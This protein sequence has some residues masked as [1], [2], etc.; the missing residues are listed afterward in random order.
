M[1]PVKSALSQLEPGSPQSYKGL[2]IFPLKSSTGGSINYLLLSEALEAG[3]VSVRESSHGG[4]VPDLEVENR[5][6]RPV[7]I[8]DGEEL[9]GAKQNRV[10]N[11]PLLVPAAKRTT[12]PV[13]CVEAGR[14][15]Y[16]SDEFALS[17]R[18]HFARGRREK[19]ASVQASMRSTGSRYSDQ[20]AV[21]ASIDDKAESMQARSPTG[22]MGSIFEKHAR[23]L[24]EFVNRLQAVPG[25]VGGVFCVAGTICGMD[26]FDK[27]TTFA[28]LLPKLVRSYGIDALEHGSGTDAAP[29]RNA[30]S[31]FLGSLCEGRL[32]EHDAVGLGH[33]VRVEAAGIVA[34]GLMVDSELIHLAAFA[35]ADSRHPSMAP[36]R[37]FATVRQRR[38]SARQR[39]DLR[40]DRG[41]GDQ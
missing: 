8:V 37:R 22:A 6:D 4:S 31:R 32:D 33:D 39:Q 17:E 13:S 15:S 7:L 30:V 35:E 25:Q 23:T 20:G 28:A 24:D 21:W 36:P 3:L 38:R 14:W 16:R 5:A 19:L 26:V 29:S 10:A 12:I 2:S 9:L 18:V 40:N 11:L 34:G 27:A 41:S 1:H